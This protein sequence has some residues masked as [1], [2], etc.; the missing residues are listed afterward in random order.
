VLAARDARNNALTG[1]NM[2]T[3]NGAAA[4]RN[5]QN[6]ALIGRIVST[7]SGGVEKE[8]A[9]SNARN[10]VNASLTS[11][12]AVEMKASGR[13][14]G[15]EPIVTTIATEKGGFRIAVTASA[16]KTAAFRI[17]GTAQEPSAMKAGADCTFRRGS[18][19]ACMTC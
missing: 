11:E 17:D 8:R 3:T 19:H 16:S 12:V 13:K 5:A 7:M 10:G 14:E 1:K 18:G 9:R 2:L 6:D 15:I 4:E